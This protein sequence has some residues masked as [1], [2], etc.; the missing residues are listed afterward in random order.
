[1]QA[2]KLT[3]SVKNHRVVLDVPNDVP[4]G[5]AEVVLLY[6]EKSAH[7]L[8]KAQQRHLEALFARIDQ[9]SPQR[10]IEDMDRQIAEE[11]DSWGD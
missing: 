1:M 9:A 5:Q 3:V 10:T 11:R 6:E 2:L 4:D 7:D 8:A